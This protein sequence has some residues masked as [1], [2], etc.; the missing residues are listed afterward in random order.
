MRRAWAVILVG[1][2]ARRSG[3]VICPRGRPQGRERQPGPL[4][5]CSAEVGHKGDSAVTHTLTTFQPWKAKLLQHGSYF[6]VAFDTDGDPSDYERCAFAF[7]RGGIRGQ[8]TNC[9]RNKVGRIGVRKES[10]RAIARPANRR[11]PG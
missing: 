8:L 1:R 4:D 3:D 9:G 10:G 11:K 7:F 5:L 2:A 6:A